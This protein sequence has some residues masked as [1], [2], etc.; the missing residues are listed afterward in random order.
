M[1][2]RNKMVNYVCLRDFISSCPSEIESLRV[3]H[4]QT[5]MLL[6]NDQERQFPGCTSDTSALSRIKGQLHFDLLRLMNQG[7]QVCASYVYFSVKAL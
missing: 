7:K 3:R 2:K 4:F 6:Y 5:F 1:I